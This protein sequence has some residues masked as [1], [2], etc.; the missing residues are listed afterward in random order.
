M[1]TIDLDGLELSV[2]SL[3]GRVQLQVTCNKQRLRIGYER[4]WLTDRTP[5]YT[6]SAVHHNPVAHALAHT[7]RRLARTLQGDQTPGASHAAA[8]GRSHWVILA[9]GLQ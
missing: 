1:T 9:A 7:R 3:L 5:L 2:P 6:Q 8:T 4:A